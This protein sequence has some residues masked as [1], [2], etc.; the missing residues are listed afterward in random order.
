MWALFWGGRVSEV[1]H[2]IVGCTME[3]VVQDLCNKKI[4]P[5]RSK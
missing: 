3:F 4:L 2:A 1:E 5:N